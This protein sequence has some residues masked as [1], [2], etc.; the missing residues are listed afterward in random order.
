MLVRVLAPAVRRYVGDGALEDRQQRVLDALAAHVAWDRWVVRLARDLVDVV[1]VD[2]S[3]IRADDVEVGRLDEPEQYV[4]HVLADVAGLREARR[5]G[6]R[7]R[8]V[9][10]LCERLREVRLAA[11]RRADQEDV[12]LRQLHVAD[13]LGRADALVVVVHLDRKDLLRALLADHVLV[14]GGADGLG[15]AAEAGLL[16]LPPA[17]PLASL[18][19]L[20][21]EVDALVADA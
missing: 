18:E 21:A 12:R 3:A 7:K 16:L 15:V 11:S 13:R 14:E 20:L 6:D 8:N 4:L 19:H 1:D 9:K 5:V 17:R 10:K 2:E